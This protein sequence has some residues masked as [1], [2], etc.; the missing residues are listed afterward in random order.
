MDSLLIVLL[1]WI[2]ALSIFYAKEADS[3][4][5]KSLRFIKIVASIVAIATII[6]GWGYVITIIISWFK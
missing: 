5:P 6:L 4:S 3:L 2:V 1:G